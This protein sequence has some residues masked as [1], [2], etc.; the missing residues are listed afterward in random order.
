MVLGKSCHRW[1]HDTGFVEAIRKIRPAK[2]RKLLN[3]LE[4]KMFWRSLQNQ[5]ITGEEY[6]DIKV[7]EL[8]AIIKGEI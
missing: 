6:V 2:D 4:N 7:R 3:S 1:A 5:G 8:R